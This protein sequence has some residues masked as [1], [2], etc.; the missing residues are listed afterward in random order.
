MDIDPKTIKLLTEL[1]SSGYFQ[2]K[3]F[4]PSPVVSAAANIG[5]DDA[6]LSTE[7]NK[8]VDAGI[9]IF[10]YDQDPM[11]HPKDKLDY[12]RITLTEEGKK[13]I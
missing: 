11:L 9:I 6:E 3:P 4:D 12:W 10:Q 7:L 1:N 8:L 13:M 2:L 5:I